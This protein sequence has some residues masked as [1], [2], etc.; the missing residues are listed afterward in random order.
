MGQGYL[1]ENLDLEKIFEDITSV[2]QLGEAFKAVKANKGSAG[3]DGQKI[4]D[5]EENLEEELKKLSK[6]LKEWKYKPKRVKQVEIPKKGGTRKIGIPCVRD[7]TVQQSIK[8]SIEWKI[9]KKFSEMSF[10]F[11]PGRNQHQ[12]LKKAKELIE[13][14]CDYYVDIDLEKFFDEI[15]QDRL[16][17]KVSEEIKD[18]R[19][20]RL[21]GISLR[22]GIQGK[23]EVEESRHG[24]TQGSPLSPLL[25]NL[26]LDELDKELEKR[27]LKFCRYA[28]DIRIFC[29]S[30]KAAERIMNSISKFIEKRMKLK[31][32]RKKSKTGKS[33]KTD[34]L[35]MV[36]GNGK[37]AISGEKIKKAMERVRRLTPRNNDKSVK[38]QIEKINEWLRGWF[39]YVKITEF[40]A[41]LNKIEAHIRRRLRAKIIKQKKRKRFI[42]RYLEKKNIRRD[43]AFRDVYQR[44]E[45]WAMSNT[46]SFY[47]LFD[48]KWF[49]EQGLLIFSELQLPHWESPRIW[50]KLT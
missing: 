22:S 48:K 5:F 24:T 45:T 20:I 11:R 33:E 4:E 40:P 21:I 10:G 28:D 19:V 18:N 35:G 6:E 38:E 42:L 43:S 31:V 25:S 39:E 44:G 15:P 17:T 23:L 7:R 47:T 32:N 41:Q 13:E 36:I 37:I 46:W 1:F 26:Y 9:D 34:F 30:K 12:A 27:G 49:K 29:K 16:M 2:W 14:G 50:P 8:Q 3:V